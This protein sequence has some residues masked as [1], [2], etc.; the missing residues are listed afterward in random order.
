MCSFSPIW[1]F[2][3]PAQAGGLRRETVLAAVLLIPAVLGL[4]GVY[5]VAYE[6]EFVVLARERRITA[7][8]QIAV[9]KSEFDKQHSVPA[10]LAEDADVIATV[11]NPTGA[12]VM[13]VSQK[14]QRLQIETK[15]A[16]IYILNKDGTA[17]SASNYALPASFVGSN[18]HFRK[19]YVDAM[20][21][22]EGEQFALGTVSHRPGL[23]IARRITVGHRPAGVVVVKVEFDAIEASWRRPETTTFVIDQLGN[24]LLT[25][26]SDMRFRKVPGPTSSQFMVNLPTGV[27]KWRLLLFSSRADA[28]KEAR[29]AT[30]VAA[31]AEGLL[32]ALLA[33][34]WRRRRRAV[35]RTI[36]EKKY[37]EDLEREVAT[38]TAELSNTNDRLSHE[39][40]ERQQAEERLNAM[41]AD[42]VQAN[43]LAQLGQITAGVAH[44]INQ[45][46]A[47][48]RV[49]AENC[50]ALLQR[51]LGKGGHAETVGQ[52]L[53]GIVRLNDRI[54]HITGE[55][56][57]FSRKATGH[58]EPVSLKD[59]LGS[60]LLLNRS[61]SRNNKV[62][63]SR[64]AIDGQIR[65]IGGRIR[66][67]QALVN[68][69]QNAYEAL[70][71]TEHPE[72][73]ISTT[74][75]QDW[76]F[77]KISDNGPGIPPQVLS[78]IFTPFV[79][80]KETGLGLGLVIAHDIVR[81]LGGELTAEN[82]H[83]GAT[84]ILKLRR[85]A[86]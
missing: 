9:L 42:L 37:R 6:R 36:A 75:D 63:L 73:R 70:E 60:A 82:G 74:M 32:G 53:A 39:I 79:T 44:E 78:Q 68:L 10:V 25:G 57:T 43:K 18:Y 21:Y 3:A 27:G 17:L 84:F 8:Q 30:L 66:L 58:A 77:L 16:D 23:Y 61:R 28:T 85:V 83:I 40:V 52:N 80:T 4:V 24:I 5:S 29:S 64:E 35:E 26:S 20:R 81:D 49:L 65:V 12:D 11:A 45:P 76:V 31:L 62:R 56:R 86:A 33:L 69:L 14:L 7:E 59:A 46:L 1:N 38:R 13:A 51:G 34:W 71:D 50:M 19:Y 54:G 67:E 2:V 55:L 48:I 47:A 72:V 41:Q 15:S 22:G